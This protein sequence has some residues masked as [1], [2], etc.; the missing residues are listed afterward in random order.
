MGSLHLTAEN[1][2]SKTHKERVAR[3]DPGRTGP[4]LLGWTLELGPRNNLQT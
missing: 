4:S 1:K 3:G 2:G